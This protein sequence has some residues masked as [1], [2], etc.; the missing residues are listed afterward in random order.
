MLCTFTP[1]HWTSLNVVRFR[2]AL[3]MTQAAF[4]EELGTTQAVLSRVENGKSE[5]WPMLAKLLTCM[6]E[7]RGVVVS[8]LDRP[9][10]KARSDE[11][12]TGPANAR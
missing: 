11:S 4:A 1:M 9:K 12:E 3:D 2:K 10:E 6:Y 7:K 5:I 8:G